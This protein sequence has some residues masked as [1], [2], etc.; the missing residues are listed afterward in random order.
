MTVA[1]TAVGRWIIRHRVETELAALSLAFFVFVRVA[2]VESETKSATAAPAEGDVASAQTA[3]RA[4]PEESPADVI[5]NR[6]WTIR[7]RV[8]NALDLGPV[9]GGIIV[10]HP[11]LSRHLEVAIAPDGRFTAKLGALREEA[12]MD[13]NPETAGSYTLEIRPPD[14]YRNFYWISDGGRFSFLSYDDR[15]LMGSTA[16]EG[17]SDV[18]RGDRDLE[19]AL[20]PVPNEQQESDYQDVSRRKGC[21]YTPP[22]V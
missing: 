5:P 11:P 22:D 6:Y 12:G 15:L 3:E 18:I 19:I 13:L 14:G 21:N 10:L 8:I 9:P 20:Y 7:G 16:Q 4:H 2:S 17:D 1:S